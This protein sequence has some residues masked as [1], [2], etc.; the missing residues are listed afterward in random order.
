MLNQPPK[1][2]LRHFLLCLTHHQPLL[3]QHLSHQNPLPQIRILGIIN[4]R[5][6]HG[7]LM[8]QSTM[9]NL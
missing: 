6:V 5:Q 4:C 9:G 2:L 1:N 3:Y 8:T 7:L